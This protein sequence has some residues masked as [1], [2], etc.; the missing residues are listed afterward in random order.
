YRRINTDRTSIVVSGSR[1]LQSS[2]EKRRIDGQHSARVLEFFRVGSSRRTRE[3][4][5]SRRLAER[6]WRRV[7]AG[8][9]ASA[10]V[11]KP[12]RR[13]AG[14]EPERFCGFRHSTAESGWKPRAI[15]GSTK[16]R[17]LVQYSGIRAGA[18]IHDRYGVE[19]PCCRTGIPIARRNA[20]KN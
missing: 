4:L 16:Y 20:W 6:A 8:G 19:K 14:N 18:A 10:A 5:E 7:A 13:N 9:F 12:A 3:A 11:R 2:S 15:I 17:P 1:Q